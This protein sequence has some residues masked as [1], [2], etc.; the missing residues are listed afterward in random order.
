M[1]KFEFS[2]GEE[3]LE[4]IANIIGEDGLKAFIKDFSEWADFVLEDDEDYIEDSL[5]ESESEYDSE[6][7]VFGIEVEE[8]YETIVD[9]NGF[10]SLKEC[11]VKSN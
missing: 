1:S 7:E 9:E 6:G 8:E 11:K 10:H 2:I 5:S 3:L 4:I